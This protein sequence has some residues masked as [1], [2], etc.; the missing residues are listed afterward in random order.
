MTYYQ[1]L[2]EKP[3]WVLYTLIIKLSLANIG[4]KQ[5]HVNMEIAAHFS[6]DQKIKEN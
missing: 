2:L 5:E 4:K 1:N 3:H 6:M